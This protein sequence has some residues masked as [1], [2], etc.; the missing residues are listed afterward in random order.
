MKN[1]ELEVKNEL[2][3]GW[4]EIPFKDAKENISTTNKKLLQ[5]E[6]SI[7]DGEIPV[8]DQGISFIGGYS[9]KKDLAI[10]ASSYPHIIF[11][12]HTRI[13]K[14]IDFPFAPGADGTQLLIPNDD[15]MPREFFYFM[16]SS[17]NVERM[18]WRRC[19]G[20]SYCFSSGLVKNT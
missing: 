2:P 15:E 9:N 18:N 19:L 16:I 12:D 11:G 7:S 20:S 10:N 8:I 1:E 3:T 17:I 4:I 13:V 6:Y 5:K 14:F